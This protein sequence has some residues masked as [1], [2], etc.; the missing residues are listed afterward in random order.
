M[1]K[2]SLK[3]FYK[4][5]K[6]LI[7]GVTGFKGSW[8]ALWLKYLGSKVSGVGYQPNKNKKL[9]YDLK[10]QKKIK[11]NLFD[12]RNYKKLR[13][14]VI[15]N[16]PEIIFHLAAQPLIIES[17]RKPY[18]T[19]DININGTLNLLEIVKNCNFVKSLV[20]VTSDKCYESNN[21]TKGFKEDD[22]LGGIDPYSASKA[23]MELMTRAYYKSFFEIKKN[24]IGVSSG[25]A[26]NVIGGGDWSKNRIIPDSIKSIK[27]GK[28][29]TIRNPNFNRPWQHVLEPI[30]GYLIL[31]MKQYKNPIKYSGAWNFGTK[32]NSVTSVKK[33]VK[34][35]INFW[36][37]GKMKVKNSKLYEQVN[38]QLNISKAQKKLNWSPSYNIKRSV[39][40]TVDWYKEI[41]INKKNSLE[42][43]LSQIKEYMHDSKIN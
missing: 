22:K 23:S 9:F 37:S 2:L 14:T 31:G 42:T 10:L 40:F 41:L 38:L 35:I 33:I 11:L 34:F 15:N 26:G 5:K 6:V 8:M 17:Y 3:K 28:T 12:I 4:N 19:F 43:C 27:K 1:V 30:K 18:D 16:K 24:K 25:R 32:S 13:Q 29:I 21:S 36:G 39:K 7:T 20:I